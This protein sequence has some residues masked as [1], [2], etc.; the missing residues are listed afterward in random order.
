MDNIEAENIKK[1]RRFNIIDIAAIIAVIALIAGAAW[2][3]A[4]PGAN[5]GSG[6]RKIEYTVRI[7]G[8]RPFTVPYYEAGM[9]CFDKK[10]NDFIG[11][12]KA[13]NVEEFEAVQRGTDGIPFR[14]VR[15]QL[16]TIYLT[17]EADGRET[18]D[19][20]FASSSYKL[21]MGSDIQLVTKKMDVRSTVVGIDGFESTIRNKPYTGGFERP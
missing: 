5:V 7:D 10:T 15:P 4:G 16:V 9:R 14:V 20:Y 6:A 21:R 13:V 11:V 3:F 2:R 18:A 12:I 17:I 1:R 8:V 19:S